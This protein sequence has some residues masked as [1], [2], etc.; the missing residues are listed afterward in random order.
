[1]SHQALVLA[2][3]IQQSVGQDSDSAGVKRPFR[4]LAFFVNGFGEAAHRAVIPGEDGGR[5][6]RRGAEG[7]ADDVT[8]KGGI[9]RTLNS[10]SHR[11]L[12]PWFLHA[13]NPD[14]P[15]NSTDNPG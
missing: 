5:Q 12:T 11:T 14:K 3:G 9:G 8:E 6:G 13:L 10:A 7:I 15:L 2:S 1:M 4:Q